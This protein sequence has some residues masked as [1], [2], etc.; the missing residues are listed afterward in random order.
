MGQG[1]DGNKFDVRRAPR[2]QW[3]SYERASTKRLILPFKEFPTP[4]RLKASQV[5]RVGNDI[6]S[7][8]GLFLY[9][10]GRRFQRDIDYKRP[11]LTCRRCHL[12]MDPSGLTCVLVVSD[13]QPLHLLGSPLSGASQCDV[14]TKGSIQR[15]KR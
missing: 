9:G 6:W 15:G 3:R 12:L 1:P 2:F 13:T 7:L 4:L 11:L 14:G 10:F 8:I 5:E